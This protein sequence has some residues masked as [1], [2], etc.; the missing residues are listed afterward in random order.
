ME[1]LESFQFE[2]FVHTFSFI[3][4]D[5][6]YQK[7]DTVY[8]PQYVRNIYR[9]PDSTTFTI[10]PNKVCGE[11]RS[12][13]A[14]GK[15]IHCIMDDL[16]IRKICFTRIDFCF[17]TCV[18]F[19]KCYKIN[20]LIKKLYGLIIKSRNS[21]YTFGDDHQKRS[22]K[23]DHKSSSQETYNKKIESNGCSPYSTRLEFRFYRGKP[24]RGVEMLVQHLRTVL[25]N[26]P[27][28]YNALVDQ[29]YE[30]LCAAYERERQSDYEGRILSVAEFIT[31]YANS[32]FC[33]ELTKKFYNH[34]RTG[35]FKGWLCG[36]RKKHVLT[37]YAPKDVQEY[38]SLLQRSLDEYTK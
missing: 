29:H 21:Y 7:G 6:V 2:P 24:I 34:Y 13:K 10:N 8:K 22:T 28:Y 16:G 17:N 35:S 14:L 31:K 33:Y 11:L 12:I 36:Y 4:E 38:L 18:D 3:T 25:I 32:F 23:V 5:I 9:H 19:E 15:A 20:D 30:Y 26:L 27:K 37:F 1:N